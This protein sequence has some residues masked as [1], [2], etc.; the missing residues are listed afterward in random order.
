MSR[1]DQPPVAGAD[2][3]V[4]HVADHQWSDRRTGWFAVVG[5]QQ[6]RRDRRRT[7]F[8]GPYDVQVR[9]EVPRDPTTTLGP[10]AVDGVDLGG[11]SEGAI[12]EPQ[13]GVRG[14]ERRCSGPVAVVDLEPQRGDHDEELAMQG[15]KWDCRRRVLRHRRWLLTSGGRE[16]ATR[17]AR[18]VRSAP[19]NRNPLSLPRTTNRWPRSASPATWSPA[20]AVVPITAPTEAARGSRSETMACSRSSPGMR[21]VDTARS[22]GPM[23]TASMPGTAAIARPSAIADRLSSCAT[24]VT[25]SA[26]AR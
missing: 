22:T 11:P 21:P 25:P 2:E 3:L 5:E 14:E 15:R 4:D 10:G 18:M 6:Q 19:A 1:R 24:T 7:A 12:D 13:L 16:R 23:N 17:P 8:V 20:A 9:H 26:S